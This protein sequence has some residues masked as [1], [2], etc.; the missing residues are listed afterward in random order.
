MKAGFFQGLS[1][2]LDDVELFIQ[3]GRIHIEEVAKS[4]KDFSV[5]PEL[6]STINRQEQ[7]ARIKDKTIQLL[8]KEINKLVIDLAASNKHLRQYVEA[9]VWEEG[10]GVMVWDRYRFAIPLKG[11]IRKFS[12]ENDGVEVELMESNNNQFPVGS[13]IWVHLHQLS[14]VSRG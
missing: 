4:L 8:H 11:R 13:C 7:V 12:T 6:R 1:D 14:A 2:F 5:D 9:K 3:N 10:Q